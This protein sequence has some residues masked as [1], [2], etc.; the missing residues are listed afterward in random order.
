VAEAV[1][2]AFNRTVIAT[3]ELVETPS[4]LPVLIEYGAPFDT[5]HLLEDGRE[6]T[7]TTCRYQISIGGEVIYHHG[8]VGIDGVQAIEL[9]IR[10]LETELDILMRDRNSTITYAAN[11]KSVGR[12]PA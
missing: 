1:P 2:L 6:V 3:R 7:D 12:L 5:T 9:A 8:A 4:G 11:H 10:L